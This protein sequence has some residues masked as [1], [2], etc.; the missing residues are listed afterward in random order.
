MGDLIFSVTYLLIYIISNKINY[1]YK[2]FL[3][4][5]FKN[6]KFIYKK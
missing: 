2:F 3:N 4:F 5:Y 6:K 1:L